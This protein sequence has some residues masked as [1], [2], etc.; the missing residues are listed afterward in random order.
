LY[1]RLWEDAVHL[2]R[3]KELPRSL[4]GT[5]YIYRLQHH[6]AVLTPQANRIL[7]S[8]IQNFHEPSSGKV[9]KFKVK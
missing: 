8:N 5:S 1:L 7:G 6:L 9:L 3:E 2:A 4:K